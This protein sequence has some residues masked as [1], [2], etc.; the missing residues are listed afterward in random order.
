[1]FIKS[2][3]IDGFKSYGQR[4]IVDGFDPYFNAITGLNGSGK[5]NILDSIC[6]VLGISNL[7][8]V[9]AANLQE[10]VY[11]NGQ[12]GI[13]KATV[14]I[15]FDNSDSDQSPIGYQ[16][17]KEITIT[18][19]IVIGGQN[20][21]LINGTIAT[22]S[23][24]R[25]LF[26]TVQLNVNN[27]HFLIMQGRITKV[28]NMKPLEILSMIEEAAGTKMYETKKA[29][30]QHTIEAKEAK[31]REIKTLLNEDI[32]PT[33][34]RLKEERAAFLEY[35]KVERE[36][37]H[38]TRLAVAYDYISAEEICK[39]SES[40]LAEA[41]NTLKAL[42]VNSVRITEEVDNLRQRL[43]ERFKTR[44]AER[45]EV[46]GHLEEKL[47]IYEKNEVKLK[48]NFK[49]VQNSL[50]E[51]ERKFESIE[52]QKS[53][54]AVA[55][56]EKLEQLKSS[57]VQLEEL[58]E[59]SAQDL[60]TVATAESRLQAVIAGQSCGDD[61]PKATVVQQLMDAKM[62][63]ANAETELKQSE[64]KTKHWKEEL[65]KKTE[66]LK[67]TEKDHQKNA[68]SIKPL[69]NEIHNIQQELQKVNYTEGSAED[70]ESQCRNLKREA[71]ELNEK[72]DAFLTRFQQL[73]FHYDDPAP[74][75]DRSKVKGFVCE[76]VR[77]KDPSF[78]TA[79][80]VVAG[81][82]LYNVMVDNENTGK[83]ILERGNLRR[84]HTLIPLNKIKGYP[85]SNDILQRAQQIVGKNNVWTALSLIDFDPALRSAM[86]FA[87]GGCLVCRDMELA[88][89]VALHPNIRKR[90]V[91]I[92]GEVFDPSGT[93]TGGSRKPGAP[94]L[95]ALSEMTDIKAALS[96]KSQELEIIN[97]ALAD[98]KRV[99]ARYNEL[100]RS[101]EIKQNEADIIRQSI[102]QT[103][104][105]KL[106]EEVEIIK[107][108]LVTLE[109]TMFDC[110]TLIKER[111]KKVEEL[112]L[113]MKNADK[114]RE[115]ELKNA[116]LN[117]KK[118]KD[119]AK[120][121]SEKVDAKSEEIHVL[122]LEIEELQSGVS[123]NDKQIVTAEENIASLKIQ[124]EE[125][126]V[127]IAEAEK[128]VIE[129]RER[130]AAQNHTLKGIERVIK[131]LQISENL[132]QKESEK[133]K[134]DIKAIEISIAKMT[135]GTE[136]AKNRIEE[137][138]DHFQW[139][140]EE[141]KFFGKANTQYD[142]NAV[143]PHAARSQISKL[144]DR[145]EELSRNVNMRAMS[146]L[147]RTEEQYNELMKKKEVV[148]KD[149]DTIAAVIKELDEKK[150][151][152]LQTAWVKVNADFGS[153]FSTVLPGT[154]AKLSP[155][156]GK[157]VLEG[158]EVKVAFGDT[159]KQSLNELSGG[160][161]SLVALSLI[162]ALL[163]F[164]PAPIYIL[165]E[166]D[167]ALDLSHTQNIG[168][169]L[170]VHFKHSQFIIVSLKDGMFNNAN[171]LFKTKFVDGMSA[172]SR[173]VQSHR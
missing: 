9:R 67:K 45:K 57:T 138:L 37:E 29:A 163:L 61:G 100:K 8:Q 161:R 59:V 31:L 48:S 126:T 55:I 72:Y 56:R 73:D 153:I 150:K 27:P 102:A 117:V 80:E 86:E 129:G 88:K 22:N 71:A 116:E 79:I 90:T 51:E 15:T 144:K 64:M 5:S 58:K 99:F 121:S 70:L 78:A 25:D 89:K 136:E 84:R 63:I 106:L 166:V 134:L 85:I 94:F 69:E 101:L 168:N 104:H 171:V 20:K 109:K 36:L 17:Y 97:R 125:I 157:S 76:A 105:H 21:Y 96:E 146:L 93:L 41:G 165:D 24:V 141:K 159:W 50:K 52:Q 148:K 12:T 130:V 23:R 118:C 38:L 131:E 16:Q 128:A 62:E 47:S 87:F 98:T 28:L 14:S 156:E 158:L 13:T 142:F 172:V 127:A 3:T 122:K 145:K 132:L 107:L 167:A 43:N 65:K 112:E 113:M 139:I 133:N 170:K 108:S 123:S 10:L 137:L 152:A 119:N 74:N 149:K 19:Q 83:S 77:L 44:D 2:I 4:T 160:Q 33:L 92:D 124:I 110:Q 18:R 34:T 53:N 103:V 82:K 120:L 66:E 6:F 49:N 162:L 151:E 39:K 46:L 26:H 1:M 115:K 155:L 30:A 164:K 40:D 91:T 169:M 11:K 173:H 81:G 95:L 111:T 60:E 147:D 54:E 68:S 140:N 114:I 42:E 7:S 135:T 32:T 35:Q 143:D 154:Q 75:F